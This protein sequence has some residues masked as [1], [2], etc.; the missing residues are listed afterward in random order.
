[1]ALEGFTCQVEGC[2]EDREVLL[3][4][5]DDPWGSADL[6]LAQARQFAIQTPARV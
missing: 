5:S 1:M 3:H 4:R 2:L 6:C